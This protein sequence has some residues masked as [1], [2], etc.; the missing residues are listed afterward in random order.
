MKILYKIFIASAALSLISCDT[1]FD[2]KV[3]DAGFYDSGTADVSAFV[4]VGNSLTAGYADNALYIAGQEYSFPNILASRFAFAGGGEFTQPLMADNYGG[5]LFQGQ[6]ITNNR[7][8]LSFDAEGNPAPTELDAVPTTEVTDHLSGPFHNMGVPGAKSFHLVAN[9]YG[10]AAGV[11]AGLANPYF[12]RF[13]STASAS[14]I[15]DA[16]TVDATF[17]SLWIGNNDILGYATSGGVGVDQAGNMDPTTYGGNDITDPNVF[18]AVYSQLLA[19]LTANGA[20][21]VVTNIPDVTTIPYFT[22]V[23]YNAVPMDEATAAMVNAN[24]AGYN[25]QILPLMVQAGVIDGEEAA[26]RKVNFIAGQN[27]PIIVDKDLTDLTAILIS[28]GVDTATANLVGQLRQ[29]NAEDLLLLPS[30]SV[31]GTLADPGNPMSIMGVAVPLPDGLVLTKK[32]QARVHSAMVSYNSTIQALAGQH[33][34]AFVDANALL[35][36]LADGGLPYDAGMLTS[37]YVTGGAFS[38]DGVHPTARGY[39]FIANEM[40]RVINSKFNANLP[41]VKIGEYPT[42]TPHNNTPLN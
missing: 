23:P 3:T 28:Q 24:F 17:F 15:E 10:N 31:I 11:P 12:A 18:G 40:V 5:L 41:V 35:T 2:E 16:M 4:A 25:N 1:D 33:D 20:K 38:L 22:T 36:Q 34:L 8:V 29:A 6:K 7:M 27:A 14:V 9:G 39:A 32:E 13:A 21:G 19:G 26:L 42:V 30:S 37:A